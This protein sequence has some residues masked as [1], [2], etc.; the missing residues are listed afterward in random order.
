[1]VKIFRHTPECPMNDPENQNRNIPAMDD[2]GNCAYCETIE[3]EIDDREFLRK[4]HK[5]IG[6]NTDE[7]A[8]TEHL[9]KVRGQQGLN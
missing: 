6:K 7:A 1:M 4:A 2:E 5:L 9:R 8:L 3:V